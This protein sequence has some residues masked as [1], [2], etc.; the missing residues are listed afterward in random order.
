MEREMVKKKCGVGYRDD[1]SERPQER[2]GGQKGY[3]VT[4]AW[5]CGA[6]GGAI[7]SC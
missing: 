6:Q 4:L 7:M 2:Y 1:I 5:R 3:E